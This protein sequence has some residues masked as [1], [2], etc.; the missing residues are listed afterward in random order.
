MTGRVC[1][2]GKNR[3]AIETLKMV[4]ESGFGDG[5]VCAVV[6]RTDDGCDAWQPSFRRFAETAGVRIR[7]LDE[8]QDID[9][10]VFL[11]V[12]FDRIVRPARFTPSSR[13]YNIHF[14]ALPAYKGMFTSCHPILRGEIETGC[15]LHDI[16]TGIDTGDIIAQL[17]F[18]IDTHDTAK[19]LY[20]KY[21][22]YG[23]D[24]IANNIDAMIAGTVTSVPQ[25]VQGS[26]YFSAA[27]IDYRGIRID[28]NQTC[29]GI[30]R[31]VNAFNHR[32]Y[33]LPMVE[34]HTI[35]AAQPLATRSTA[36]PGSIVSEGDRQLV[37]A[38]IDY[39]CALIIDRF[40][41]LVAAIDAD[42]CARAAEILADNP[43]LLEE[44]GREGW[45]PLILAAFNGKNASVNQLLQLGADPNNANQ[46]G[47]TPLMYAKECYLRTGNA[48]PFLQLIQQGADPERRDMWGKTLLDY[49]SADRRNEVSKL[50][51]KPVS[52]G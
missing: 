21:I 9:D 8:V 35:A 29:F 19:T 38:T 40:D 17:R 44:S 46:K 50:I 52:E 47:T 42:L 30:I 12:E 3:I 10:L 48:Q 25:P 13:L 22:R 43:G 16:D 14:S 4:L 31:Q 32:S 36:K 26:T 27:S 6:N 41:E 45:T 5:S 2:A 49:V 11:S 23:I 34:G 15:T 39:D 28:L 33:Q 37:V 24:L 1:V 20:A 18:P 51:C 7:T